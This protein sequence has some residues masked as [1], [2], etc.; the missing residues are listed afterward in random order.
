MS[1]NV[2]IVHAHPEPTSLTRQMA[3][4]ADAALRA[5]GHTVARSDLHAMGWK[6]VV[7]GDDFPSRVDPERLSVVAESGH[8]FATGQLTEDVLAEQRKVLAAD[9]VIL[10]FPLWW[11]GM[12]AILKGWIDRVWAY[13]L[14]YGVQG[15]GNRHRYGEGGLQGRRALVSVTTGGPASDY[16]PRGINGALDELL[17]PIT[18]GMLFYPGMSVLPTHAVYGTSR[19]DAT[20]VEAAKAAWRD[21]LAGIF[22]EPPIRY[23]RQNGGDYPDLHVL[24]DHIAPGIEGVRVHVESAG[25]DRA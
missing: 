10:Q 21:R 17:F 9:L 25:A 20:Q 1:K 6:A 14:A 5:A 15:A 24:A 11:F 8:G 16:G 3:D 13:G 19:F 2:L 7:D 22:D 23:R 4:V 18:H 12:P